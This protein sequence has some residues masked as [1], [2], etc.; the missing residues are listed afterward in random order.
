MF[1][2]TKKENRERRHHRIRAKINGTKIRPRLSVFRSNKHLYAQLID[3]EMENTLAAANDL[4]ITKSHKGKMTKV[5]LAKEIG[6]LIAEKGGKKKIK[7]VV[8]DRGGFSYHGQVKALAEGAR[9]G[10]LEF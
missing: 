2:N 9:E 6:K 4:E 3:D 10:G 1:S 5:E 7:S 8:L